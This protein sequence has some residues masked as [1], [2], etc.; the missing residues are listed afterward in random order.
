VGKADT[1]T[2]EPFAD[3]TAAAPS[4]TNIGDTDTGVFFPAANILSVATG[5]GQRLR[6]EGGITTS[7]NE[8]Y[9]ETSGS[10]LSA[11]QPG[12]TTGLF[13]IRIT[14]DG[15]FVLDPN[16]SAFA[17][18]QLILGGAQTSFSNGTVSAPSITNT[19]DLNT[20]VFFPAADTIAFAEG[21]VERLRIADAGQI[22][23][24]GANYGTSGQV[25]TSGGP[26]AAPSWAS[27]GAATAGLAYDAVGTYAFLGTASNIAAST[28]LAD[29][30]GLVAGS[31][32]RG[33]GLW[34]FA[35]TGA[36]TSSIV[37]S[38]TW[39]CMGYAFNPAGGSRQVGTLFLRIS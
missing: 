18:G 14:G 25:L 16:T 23:I 22:G 28:L 3:G 34:Q 24:G 2:I 15:R 17:P 35:D 10:I 26:S 31:Q 33:L 39:R 6:V 19:N 30:G 9:L 21:G 38:G 29:S 32:L 37:V 5:G 20:G 1:K 4:I 27:V 8:L 12:Y 11:Y 7:Y 36:N 13:N